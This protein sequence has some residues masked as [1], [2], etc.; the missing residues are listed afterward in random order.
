MTEEYS[1]TV[2]VSLLSSK[3]RSD[4]LNMSNFYSTIEPDFYSTL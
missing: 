2:V 1:L 3:M 4:E